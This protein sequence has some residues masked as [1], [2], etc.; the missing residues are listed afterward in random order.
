MPTAAHLCIYAFAPSRVLSL[1]LSLSLS[2]S[3]C[4]RTL[5]TA[6]CSL[7]T[8]VNA[9]VDLIV[10]GTELMEALNLA[11]TKP[12]PHEV[13]TTKDELAEVFLHSFSTGAAFER[14]FIDGQSSLSYAWLEF[15]LYHRVYQWL[16]SYIDPVTLALQQYI[17]Q[18]PCTGR[19]C[20]WLWG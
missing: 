20:G 1:C 8:R 11:P 14:T 6:H 2:L 19:L 16:V 4:A 18:A 12:A 7:G 15:P 9:A 17:M 5:L 3:Y 10:S 13:I